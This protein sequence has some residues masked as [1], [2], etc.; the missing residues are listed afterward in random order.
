MKRRLIWLQSN[1]KHRGVRIPT[2]VERCSFSAT[3]VGAGGVVTTGT[4]AKSV[5]V[6]ETGF[7]SDKT[8]HEDFVAS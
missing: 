1:V 7:S 8:L 6:A 5:P 2:K 3:S 4:K